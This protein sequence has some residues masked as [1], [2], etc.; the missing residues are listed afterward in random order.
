MAGFLDEI[1]ERLGYLVSLPERTLR[2]LAAV[3]GGTTSLLTDT[4]FPEVLRGTTMY[5]IFIG[6]AQKFII[7]KIAEVQAQQDADKG[8]PGASDP[9]YLQKKMI[10]GALETAGLLAMHFSPLWVFAVAGDAAAGTGAFLDRLVKHLKRN[11]VIAEETQVKGL[12]DVLEAMQAA[13]QRSAS[14]IDT[15]PLS[16]EEINKLAEEMTST[17]QNMF[18]SVT[19]LVPRL[20]DLWSRMERVASREN[21]SLERI[22]GILTVDVASWGKKGFGAAMAVGQTG[23]GLFG[24]KVLDSYGKTLNA[25]SEQGVTNYLNT[26]MKPFLQAAAAHFDPDRKTWTE[27]LLTGGR[28]EEAKP[29]EE[30]PAEAPTGQE[31]PA[32]QSDSS[33]DVSGL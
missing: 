3:A 23:A 11:G 17:Y 5:R 22:G 32:P 33:P 16:R 1:R 18:S 28:R 9:A 19:N 7:E 15:P 2:S 14:A 20:D 6:D 24:E 13:S 29:G 26:R 30:T 10:G 25:V 4:L 27:A 31:S 21:V 12:T 8:D